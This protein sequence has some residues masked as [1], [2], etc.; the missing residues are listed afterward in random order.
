MKS[1]LSKQ[2]SI[3]KFLAVSFRKTLKILFGQGKLLCVSPDDR[4]NVETPFLFQGS[5]KANNF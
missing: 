2:A 5:K 3:L 1:S 4:K